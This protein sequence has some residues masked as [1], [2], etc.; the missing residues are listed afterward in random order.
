[1]RSLR[2]MRRNVT[3]R[4]VHVISPGAERN[5]TQGRWQRAATP[6]ASDPMTRTPP[7]VFATAALVVAYVLGGVIAVLT[8]IAT[9]SDV[10]TNGTRTSAPFFM[11]VIEPLAGYA[12]LR[13]HRA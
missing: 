9:M 10:L 8:D 7:L 12:F 13:G 5:R 4:G 11:L 6:V 3:A 1:M 2:R